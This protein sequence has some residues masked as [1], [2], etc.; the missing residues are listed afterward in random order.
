MKFTFYN[1]FKCYTRYKSNP[2]YQ[3]GQIKGKNEIRL[4]LEI[5]VP[6]I[7]MFLFVVIDCLE[8]YRLQSWIQALSD[9][10]HEQRRAHADALLEDEKHLGV[11]HSTEQYSI[12]NTPWGIPHMNIYI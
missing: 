7:F 8:Q 4:L 3:I 9:V 5:P 6:S 10:L 2:I 11:T 1:V 12:G